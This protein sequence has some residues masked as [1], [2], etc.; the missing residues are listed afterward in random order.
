[1]VFLLGYEMRATARCPKQS[2]HEQP[3]KTFL[4]FHLAGCCAEQSD[5]LTGILYDLRTAIDF[6]Q[7]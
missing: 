4:V 3:A 7:E 5:T 6:A 1:M 2:R